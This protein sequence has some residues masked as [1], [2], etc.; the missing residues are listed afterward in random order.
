MQ[1]GLSVFFFF[2]LQFV[3][4]GSVCM[5]EDK[6][7]ASVCVFRSK[8][9]PSVYFALLELITSCLRTAVPMETA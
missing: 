6:N 8:Q 3:Q 7:K 5:F 9:E 4:T 2:S 1:W